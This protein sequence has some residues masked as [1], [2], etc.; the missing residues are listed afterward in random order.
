MRLPQASASYQKRVR[1][2]AYTI[3]RLGRVKRDNGSL[4]QAVKAVKTAGRRLED[5]EDEVE[6]RIAERDGADDDLDTS[7]KDVRRIL[8]ARSADATSTAPYVSIFPEGIGYY[9]EA[10]LDI[11]GD[12]YGELKKRIELHL[13]AKDEVRKKYV[14]LLTKQLAAFEEPYAAVAAARTA[15]AIASTAL[16]AA[17]D[18]LDRLL[19]KIYGGLIA[20]LGKAEAERFFSRSR[21]GRGR[22]ADEPADPPSDPT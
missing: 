21:T 11:N 8:S 14:P 1:F 7:A 2:G 19:E 16:D 22:Q 5:L 13:D 3:A 17:E 15:A 9:T 4:K 10:T 6:E 18:N 20:D 12:R